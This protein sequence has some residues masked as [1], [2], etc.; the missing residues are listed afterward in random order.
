M[1]YLSKLFSE[2]TARRADKSAFTLIELLV[3]IAI[4]AILAAMLLPALASAKERAMRISCVN[5][6]KQIGLG[7]NIYAPDNGDYVPQRSWPSGQNPWQTYEVCRVAGDGKTVNR[8]PYNLGLLY[9]NK[10]AGDGKL[11]YCPSL[12]KTASG[13]SEFE[14]YSTQG[15]PSTPVGS[16]DDNIRAGYDY[17]PQPTQLESVSTSYG[18]YS[19][20]VINN[21]GVTISFTPPSGT[22]NSLKVYTP[23]LKLSQTDPQKAM[24][25]DQ[26]MKMSSLGHKSGGKASGVSVLFGDSHVNFIGVK[27]N[28]QKGSGAPFDPN[29]W[30]DLSGGTGPGSDKDAFRIIM[31]GFKP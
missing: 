21:S 5:N 20:P 15:Y 16:G 30:S 9:F 2:K 11:F 25:V 19:L 29:L 10:L 23:P 1:K 17:Y 26:I 7:V 13:N 14:Y 18:T 27:A 12:A 28:S 24:T 31:N 22:V 4:I 8:G 3:V 6:L